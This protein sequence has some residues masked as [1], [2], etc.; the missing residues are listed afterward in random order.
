M[1]YLGSRWTNKVCHECGKK[2]EVIDNEWAYRIEGKRHKEIFFCSWH[3]LRADEKRRDVKTNAIGKRK[4]EAFRLF[5]QGARS[6]EVMQILNV[7]PSTVHNYKLKWHERNS[8]R[9]LKEA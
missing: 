4:E 9:E 8:E 5:D 7:S 2:F 3:C 6:C 1:P